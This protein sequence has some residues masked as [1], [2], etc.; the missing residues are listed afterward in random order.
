MEMSPLPA[1]LAALAAAQPSVFWP[2]ALAVSLALLMR[3][4]DHFTAAAETVGRAAGLS[5]FV[6][7]V[8][9]V[10][11][12]TSLPELVASVLAVVRDA[13]E[14]VMGNVLGSNIAN[15][16]LVLGLGAVV[17][18]RLQIHRQLGDVDLPLLAAATVL[19][20]LMAVDGRVV[21]LEA[22]LLVVALAVYIRVCLWDDDDGALPVPGADGARPGPRRVVRAGLV[23]V[24]SG[25]VIWLA[26]EGTVRSVVEIGALFAIPIET[27]AATAVA[28][29]TSLPEVAVTLLAARRGRSEMAVGN[30]IGSNVFNLLAVA[31]VAGLIGPLAVPPALVL[32]ALPTMAGITLVAVLMLATRDIG[33][34]EGAFLLVTYAWFLLAVTGVAS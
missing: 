32:L 10:A 2:V 26:A 8:V 29:G 34:G 33:R 28:I 25:A 11:F 13:G 27:I 9:I 30:I 20:A 15:L 7:G 16:G 12:G 4:A 1:P 5:A 17:A 3:G 21:R 18:G 31:G 14:I 19:A 23:L 24:V 6:V 22:G